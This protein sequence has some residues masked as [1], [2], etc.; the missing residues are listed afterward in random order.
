MVL[1][2]KLGALPPLN[3]ILWKNA[4]AKRKLHNYLLESC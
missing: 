2:N 4:S 3:L 1:E